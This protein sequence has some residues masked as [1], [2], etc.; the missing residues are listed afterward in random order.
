MTSFYLQKFWRKMVLTKK[1]LTGLLQTKQ[2]IRLIYL[3][4]ELA[5][6]ALIFSLWVKFVDTQLPKSGR[7]E[8]KP[9]SVWSFWREVKT[10][11]AKRVRT[12]SRCFGCFCTSKNDVKHSTI[13][14]HNWDKYH[15]H[16]AEIQRVQ[17]KKWRV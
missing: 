2:Q 5:L 14:H 11:G 15:P 4:S 6:A 13:F 17:A 1:F 10:S 3:N 9:R 16:A 8:N 12:K 7:K